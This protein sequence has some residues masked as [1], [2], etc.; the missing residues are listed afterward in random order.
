MDACFTLCSHHRKA[1]SP[2]C[3]NS[4]GVEEE[5]SHFIEGHDN[6]TSAEHVVHTLSSTALQGPSQ[7]PAVTWS[8]SRN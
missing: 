7:T 4:I 1:L 2:A 5:R 8:V 3:S 6:I